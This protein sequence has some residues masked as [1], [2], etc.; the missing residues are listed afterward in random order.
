VQ[1]RAPGT[2][3][4]SAPSPETT[5]GETAGVQTTVGQ[6][7]AAGGD[8]TLA[9]TTTT[10]SKTIVIEPQTTTTAN[11]ATTA[12]VPKITKLSPNSGLVDG[13]TS[14][15]IT[16]TGFTGATAVTFGGSHAMYKVESATKIT[17]TCPPHAPG[18]VDVVVVGPNGT[19]S[20]A[21]SANDYTYLETVVAVTGV[22]A[23]A[24]LWNR[25][26][27]TDSH[28][29]YA[30]TWVPGSN[31]SASGGGVTLA[32]SDGASVTITF[33]GERIRLYGTIGPAYG[34][35]GIGFANGVLLPHDFYNPAE[36]FNQI[37]WD[38]GPLSK[39]TYVVKMAWYDSKNAAS[40][41]QYIDLD[42]VAV[43]RGTLQ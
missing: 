38:S 18:T 4:T 3:S 36:S 24:V 33:T 7:T 20:T 25:Y 23:G 16:G 22:N 27:E 17:A 13:L 19:S 40:Q 9:Q 39:G 1:R 12:K 35:A 21:G 6:N 29:Q 30:G 14:V 28:L 10:G 31:P 2:T 34:V 42:R 11:G 37:L 26:E 32:Y 8:T 5:T 41:G 15:V 43:L